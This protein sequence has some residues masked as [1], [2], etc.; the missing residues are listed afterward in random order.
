MLKVFEKKRGIFRK[1]SLEEIDSDAVSWLNCYSPTEEEISLISRKIGLKEERLLHFLQDSTRPHIINSE[2]FSAIFFGIID[3]KDGKIQ[4]D[5]ILI[6]LLPNNNILTLSRNET[7]L[8]NDLENSILS[9]EINAS[10]QSNF[11]YNITNSVI[12]EMSLLLENI[13]EQINSI[14]EEVIKR[15]ERSQISKLFGIKRQIIDLHKTAI[16]NREV[17][18]SVE[19]GYCKMI[20]EKEAS[21]FRF[22]YNDLFQ[23][24]DTSETYRDLAIGI[25]EIYLSTISNML[26]NTIKKMTAWG[27]LI[28]IPTLIASIYGMNFQKVS[29]WSMPELYWEYGYVFALGLIILSMVSLY[30]YFKTK[31]WL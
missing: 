14:E 18:S 4:R 20:S 27:S 16:A 30:I 29:E 28:L 9:K 23:L 12:E 8:L 5:T 1:G 31:K 17:V 26:N 10:T 7:T 6:F 19:K 24:I 11:V 13:A 3:K 2:H 15:P 25:T 21:E 22:L